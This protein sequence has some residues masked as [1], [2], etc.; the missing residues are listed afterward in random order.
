MHRVDPDVVRCEFQRCGLGHAAHRPFR[1]DVA[2]RTRETD[3]AGDGADVDDA[4]AARGAQR[5]Q[6]MAQA[7]EGAELVDPHLPLDT[8][9]V[10]VFDAPGE[11]DAGVVDHDVQLAEQLHRGGHRFGPGRVAADVVG[12]EHAARAQLGRQRAA[13]LG[14]H[15]GDGHVGAIGQ[16]PAHDRRADAAR[17]AGD[18]RGLALEGSVHGALLVLEGMAQHGPATRPVH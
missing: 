2:G 11:V 3:Q 17:A 15:V 18:Q 12:D 14:Q 1:A 10:G 13:F 4:A 7:Q 9:Q 8:F 5:R 16:Q 6:R